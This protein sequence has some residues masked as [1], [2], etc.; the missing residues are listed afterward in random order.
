MEIFKKAE[1]ALIPNSGHET[2]LENPEIR[3][4]IGREYLNRPAQ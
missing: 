1:P 2:F 4:K 3:I